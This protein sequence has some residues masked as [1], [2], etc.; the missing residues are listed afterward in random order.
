MGSSGSGK[1]GTYRIGSDNSGDMRAKS[2][3][4]GCPKTIENLKLEDIATSEYYLNRK[5]LPVA[6]EE[7]LLY[8]KVFNGRLVVKAKSTNEIIG[9]VPTQ[10]NYLINCIKSGMNYLGTVVASG[11]T[12]VPYVIVTLNA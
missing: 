3:E 8:N 10:Y 9:N 6:G 1:F 5:S 11:V 12:P 4:V 2:A 7:V